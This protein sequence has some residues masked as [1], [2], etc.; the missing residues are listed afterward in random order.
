VL[1]P[2]LVAVMGLGGL[3]SLM[4]T[5]RHTFPRLVAGFAPALALLVVLLPLPLPSELTLPWSPALLFPEPL[6]FAAGPIP[7]A[8]AADLLLLLLA[9]EWTGLGRRH[10]R[11]T[12]RASVFFLTAA[13][14]AAFFAANGLALV[15]SWAWIDLIS[16][17]LLV[18]LH[19]IRAE[20]PR[21]LSLPLRPDGRSVPSLLI[22]F[23][24]F[25]CS[26][27]SCPS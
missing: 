21:Q 7:K 17:A 20:E 11:R 18:L 10:T 24:P 5:P 22:S 1:L 15:L 14:L 6:S 4:A 8:F 23:L 19:P 9:I 2:V 12:V 13:G 16:F 26:S 3:A 25:S 27:P